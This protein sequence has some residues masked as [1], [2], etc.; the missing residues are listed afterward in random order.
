M[1][2]D[3]FHTIGGMRA[4]FPL[5]KQRLVAAGAGIP[6]WNQTMENMLGLFLLANCRLDGKGQK[7]K[8]E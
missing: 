1:A 6:G 8:S 2:H 7:E 4:G 3:A 5:F